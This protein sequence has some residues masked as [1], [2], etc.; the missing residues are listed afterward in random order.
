MI[1]N[2]IKQCLILLRKCFFLLLTR[3]VILI[4]SIHTKYVSL[5][6][7][8]CKIQPTLIDLHPNE[9][10]QG[11]SY[12]PFGV[13]LH[14]CVESGNNVNDRSSKVCLPSKPEDLNLSM[15][16]MITGIN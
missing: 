13:N 10:I 12:Y 7:Q 8:K 4:A 1:E 11:L 9:Y 3:I 2:N 16:N 14:I 5:S 15:F 6:D